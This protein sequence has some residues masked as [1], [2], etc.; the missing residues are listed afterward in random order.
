GLEPRSGVPSATQP[1]RSGWNSCRRTPTSRGAVALAE[2]GSTPPV[3]IKK[4]TLP[5]SPTSGTVSSSARTATEVI[6]PASPPLPR[7]RR[8]RECPEEAIRLIVDPG[9][10]EQG[11]GR[12]RE[13]AVAKRDAP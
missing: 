7:H 11:S 9:G 10:E 5:R 3:A 1:I 2:T 8:R 6:G 12:A 4:S 13:V